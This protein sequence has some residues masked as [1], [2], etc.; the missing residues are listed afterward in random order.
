M[1]LYIIYIII[2]IYLFILSRN[3]DRFSIGG[4]NVNYNFY[5]DGRNYLIVN[6]GEG[7]GIDDHW[8]LLQTGT[9]DIGQFQEI[10]NYIRTTPGGNPIREYPILVDPILEYPILELDRNKYKT[11]LE[12]Y[13][14]DNELIDIILN[15]WN[16]SPELRLQAEEARI[17]L[18]YLLSCASAVNTGVSPDLQYLILDKYNEQYISSNIDYLLEILKDIQIDIPALSRDYNME[19]SILNLLLIQIIVPILSKND[20]EDVVS[21]FIGFI[22]DSD[23]YLFSDYRN[24]PGDRQDIVARII[25]QYYLYRSNQGS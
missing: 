3:Y 4:V 17:K 14:S 23:L 16:I 19:L 2:G 18:S 25:S 13:L 12:K 8:N 22:R 15:L 1:Y 24:N 7:G 6:T 11:E 5:S 20:D 21:N 10:Q 9:I